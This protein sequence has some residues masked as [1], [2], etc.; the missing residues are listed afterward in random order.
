MATIDLITETKS[1]S[2]KLILVQREL[3]DGSDDQLADLQQRI[4][5]YLAFALDGELHRL[6]PESIGRPVVI[7]LDIEH[8]PDPRTREFLAKVA[9]IVTTCGLAF[10][11]SKDESEK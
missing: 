8:E 11:I 2:Y 6:H 1:G 10:V 7:Q 9:D 4:N 5:E 3:W